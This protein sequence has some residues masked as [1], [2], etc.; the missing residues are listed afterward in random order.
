MTENI[1]QALMEQSRLR[2]I[3]GVVAARD[4]QEP[5]VFVVGGT[6]RDI[7]LGERGPTSTSRSRARRALSHTCSPTLS[8]V[9]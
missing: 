1:G 4:G 2:A 5:G 8:T 9:A 6:V 3:V 7:L